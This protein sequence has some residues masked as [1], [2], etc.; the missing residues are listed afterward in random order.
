MKSRLT[1]LSLNLVCGLLADDESGPPEACSFSWIRSREPPGAESSR[2]GNAPSEAD[3]EISRSSTQS[4]QGHT[5]TSQGA[6]AAV[7]SQ[8]ASAAASSQGASV[9]SRSS[10][11]KIPEPSSSSKSRWGFPSLSLLPKPKAPC[12]EVG[13]ESYEELGMDYPDDSI[14]SLADLL[15]EF[16]SPPPPTRARGS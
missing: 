6:S 5:N 7:S 13:Q 14:T 2:S 9:P 3:E 11:A 8:G 16:P 4:S 1:V 12:E 10:A 15:D